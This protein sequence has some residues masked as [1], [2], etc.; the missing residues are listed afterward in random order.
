MMNVILH[1]ASYATPA[2]LLTVGLA[3]TL[4]PTVIKALPVVLSGLFSAL[5]PH[6]H[7]APN[8]DDLFTFFHWIIWSLSCYWL[9]LLPFTDVF[10]LFDNPSWTIIFLT[11]PTLTFLGAIFRCIIGHDDNDLGIFGKLVRAFGKLV[12]GIDCVSLGFRDFAKSVH[13]GAMDGLSQ[14]SCSDAGD[15]D[16][17]STASPPC[18]T[19]ACANKT[20]ACNY[21]KLDII[22]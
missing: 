18:Y 9:I 5:I 22:V 12:C 17:V 16:E 19:V 3:P 8:H 13:K 14:C 7:P 21:R 2:A 4:L 15:G 1:I 11:L 6:F 20:S 10:V